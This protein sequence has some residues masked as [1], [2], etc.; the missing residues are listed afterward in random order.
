MILAGN[1]LF[2]ELFFGELS[3]YD[4][5]YIDN[6]SIYLIV[7]MVNNKGHFLCVLFILLIALI[8]NTKPNSLLKLINYLVLLI[9][10][11][12]TSSLCTSNNL[13]MIISSKILWLQ[14]K[15]CC[16]FTVAPRTTLVFS[17]CAP[18]SETAHQIHATFT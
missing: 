8:H 15:A 11:L 9:L 14:S 1:G 5:S 10:K 17:P 7:K 18:R 6:F 12:N 3:G 2:G 16:M 4:L 13:K